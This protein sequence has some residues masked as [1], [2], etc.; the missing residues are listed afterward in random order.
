MRL[1]NIAALIYNHCINLQRRYYRLYG[2][3]IQKFHLQKHLVKLKATQKFAYFRK[4]DAQSICDITDRID[5]AY[6]LFWRNIKSNIK[7]SSPKLQKIRNYKSFTLKRNNWKLNEAERTIII[8]GQRYKY[9][10]SR[11]IE[12]KV[13][14]VTVKRDSLGNIC[15]YFVCDTNIKKAESQRE[16]KCVGYD[17]G[18]KRFLT[19]SDG[20]DI[21]A[22]LF[23]RKNLRTIQKRNKELSRKK[24]YSNRFKK[25][26]ISLARM[27]KRISNMRRDFHHKTAR[28]IC[29][30]YTVICIEK[31]NI[32]AMQK[33]WGRKINDLAFYSFVQILKYQ[34]VKTGTTIIEADRYYPSSQTCSSCG[35]KNESLKKLNVRKWTCPCC[36]AEH[37]RDRNAAINILMQATKEAHS[38]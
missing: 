37:D 31:L 16:Y 15:I 13:K 23:F 9:F 36:G 4:L 7:A 38:L 20:N 29:S 18:L 2:K 3:Y 28:A 19:A 25:A 12:G 5:R 22:P 30:E 32:K 14:T 8:Q 34:A 26:K 6:K 35:Y 11:T 33:L 21:E 10:K 24:A 17:F 1:I 27:Y